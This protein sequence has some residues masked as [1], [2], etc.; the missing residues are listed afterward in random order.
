MNFAYGE[1]VTR[2]RGIAATDPYSGEPG[3]DIDWNSP[4]E[5]EFS[6]FA[7]APGAFV[8][9]ATPDRTRVDI[10]FTLYGPFAADIEPLDRVVVRGQTCEVVGKRQDWRNPFTGGEAGCVVEVRKVAG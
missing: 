9:D 10:L 1:T 5:L 8:E 2:Q 3:T 7:V 4:D 6:G